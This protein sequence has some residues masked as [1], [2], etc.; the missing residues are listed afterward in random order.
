MQQRLGA[1]KS[2]IAFVT[3]PFETF[4]E[5][6]DDDQKG[7]LAELSGQRAPFAPKVPATQSCTPSEVLPWP[8]SEIEARL[9]LNDSQREGLDGLHRMSAL[10]RNTLNFNCQPDENLDQPDRLA[11]A[12]TRLDAIIDAIKLLRPALDD[13]LAMLS[14]EQKGCAGNPCADRGGHSASGGSPCRTTCGSPHRATLRI[15]ALLRA[16][17]RSVATP[18]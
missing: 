17:T 14:D 7:K 10:A 5:L 3:T 16:W 11:T 9:H 15:A 2:A 6:L 1:M 12:D 8:G 18:R 4:C 13:F